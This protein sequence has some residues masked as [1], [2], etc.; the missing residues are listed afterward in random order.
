M[1]ITFLIPSGV[2]AACL[3]GVA[4]LAGTHPATF[5]FAP[6]DGDHYWENSH[7]EVVTEMDGSTRS[8]DFDVMDTKTEV[9]WKKVAE[10]VQMT[11]TARS[12]TDTDNGKPLENPSLPLI[13]NRTTTNVFSKDGTFLRLEGNENLIADAERIFPEQLHA[14]LEAAFE[15]ATL[16]AGERRLW[17]TAD[18]GSLL[19]HEMT[20]NARWELHSESRAALR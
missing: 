17:E 13:L 14:S 2:F 16:E 4:A 3:C 7:R 20:E 11:R 6:V 15:P 12:L 10:S 8:Q 18:C 9:S 19:G 5:V 1:R